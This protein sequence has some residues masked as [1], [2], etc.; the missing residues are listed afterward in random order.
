MK[1]DWD[2]DELMDEGLVAG[3]QDPVYPDIPAE[4]PGLELV[5]DLKFQGPW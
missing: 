4:F 2:N 3:E 1:Y 5:M